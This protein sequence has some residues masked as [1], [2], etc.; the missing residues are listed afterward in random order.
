MEEYKL[1]ENDEEQ[2]A[3]YRAQIDETDKKLIE[4]LKQRIEIISKVGE[5]KRKTGLLSCFIRS[6]READMLRD[7]F[8][9]FEGTDFSPLAAC[10]IWR[11]IISASTQHECAM[12]LV[13]HES[14]YENLN[15]HATYYFG[16]TLPKKQF[17]TIKE[18][19]EILKEEPAA[20]VIL[21][22]PNHAKELWTEFATSKPETLC[23]FAAIPYVRTYNDQPAIYV[24]ANLVPEPS[25]QDSS[26]FAIED[27]SGWHFHTIAGYHKQWPKDAIASDGE[28]K[29]NR[30]LG[31]FATPIEAGED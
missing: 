3:H 21:P 26:L 11:Q 30:W 23:V 28:V 29:Q 12:S 7:I 31:T 9:E 27:D 5:L 17:S 18:L 16:E 8:T 13:I 22:E 6:G 24:A 19:A 20:L 14:E 25:R 2:L 10:T 4:L 15:H 1:P